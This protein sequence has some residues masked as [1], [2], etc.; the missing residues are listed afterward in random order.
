[1][2]ESN[3]SAQRLS[4]GKIKEKCEICEESL[5]KYR[6][7]GCLA[8]TCSLQCSK[9]HKSNTGCSGKRD[10]TEFVKKAKYNENTL[11]SDYSFLQDLQRDHI[12]TLRENEE[13]GIKVGVTKTNTTGRDTA[14]DSKSGVGTA[15]SRVQKNIIS[16]AKNNRQV[17]IRYMSPGIMRHQQNKTIWASSKSRLVWTIEIAVPEIDV[18]PRKWVE[19][20]FHD[21]CKLGDLWSRLIG[22]D[23]DT[24]KL[25]NPDGSEQNTRKRAKNDSIRIQLPSDD[26]SEHPFRSAIHK[27][28]LDAIKDK[29]GCVALT[30]LAW[31]IRVQD[32]P[33]NKPTFCT[34][35]PLQPLYTQLR[36]Q[37]V[38]EFP[39]IYVFS[40]IPSTWDGYEVKIQSQVTKSDDSS[41]QTIHALDQDSESTILAIKSIAEVE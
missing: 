33:A 27:N 13:L 9:R 36:Y 3:S 4:P 31:L 2:S 39:T 12:N 38:I 32:K 15:P 11:I 7:P 18:E 22:Y 19:T 1:M 24:T 17:L 6:C 10:R 8:R 40:G 30:Q 21:V 35:D 14:S 20:G 23:A 41:D 34:F 29:Y 5:A 25:A 28:M 16:R 37:T 26:G